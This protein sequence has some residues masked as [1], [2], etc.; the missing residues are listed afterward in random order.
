MFMWV[1]VY[2]FNI[3]NDLLQFFACTF[4]VITEGKE[5]DEVQMGWAACLSNYI[6]DQ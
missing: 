6:V 2:S 1:D 5:I 3:S 4:T